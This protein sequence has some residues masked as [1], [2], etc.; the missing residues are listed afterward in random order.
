MRVTV[1]TF[2]VGR[3]CQLVLMGPF[4]RVDLRHVT[5]FEA[6]QLTAPVRVD[7]IDGTHLA[8]E[9]PKG[10]EG[11]FEME[12]GNSAVDD[13]IARAEQLFNDGG[14]VPQGALFQYVAEPDGSTS[15][16]QFDGAVF[17]LAQAGQWRGDQS[18]KQRLEFFAASRRRV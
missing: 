1:N 13:F 5:G 14:A 12:R 16:F 8:A 9:L 11:A 3:D 15:T 17:R 10:W 4:G 18:V 7:R 6:R 2:S